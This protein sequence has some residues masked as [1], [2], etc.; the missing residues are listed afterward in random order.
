MTFLI[1]EEA[2]RQPDCAAVGQMSGERAFF[3]G[4]TDG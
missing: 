4:G 2:S 1:S 3:G